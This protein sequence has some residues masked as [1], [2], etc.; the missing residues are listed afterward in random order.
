MYL[1]IKNRST[2]KHILSLVFFISLLG[3]PFFCLSAQN[4]VCLDIKFTDD[5]SESDIQ[6]SLKDIPVKASYYSAIDSIVFTFSCDLGDMDIEI[7]NIS[8]GEHVSA[9]VNTTYEPFT[10]VCISGDKGTY[11]IRLNG[12]DGKTY[13]ASF[14]L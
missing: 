9:F 8:T 5:H 13:H 10:I 3:T 4:D 14:V 12:S 1:C 6:R 7:D 11:V 2:M